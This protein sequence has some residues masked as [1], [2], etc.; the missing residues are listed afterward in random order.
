VRW[1]VDCRSIA[2]WFDR[3]PSERKKLTLRRLPAKAGLESTDEY[4]IC[5]KPY[6]VWA[7]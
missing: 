1:C 5:M 3:V 6:H 2:L 7:A 4:G